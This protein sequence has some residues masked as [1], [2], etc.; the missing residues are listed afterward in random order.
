[1]KFGEITARHLTTCLEQTKSLADVAI[2]VLALG[3]ILL[4]GGV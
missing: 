2:T 1:M 4:I 3:I